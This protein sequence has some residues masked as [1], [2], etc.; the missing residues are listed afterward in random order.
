M[1]GG[2]RIWGGCLLKC[3]SVLVGELAGRCGY[4]MILAGYAKQRIGTY[5]A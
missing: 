2:C 3:G 5:Y 4:T 1:L